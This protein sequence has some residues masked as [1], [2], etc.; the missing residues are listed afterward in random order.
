MTVHATRRHLLQTAGFGLASLPLLAARPGFA[1][2]TGKTYKIALSNSYIGNKWR[3]EMEN[4]FKAALAM[5][6]FKSQVVGSIY[7]SGNDVSKQSQQMSN[8]IA[9][10]VDAIVIDA[11]S[12][13]ALNGI[14]HQATSRGILVVS[15]DSGVTAPSAIKVNISQYR[16]RQGLGGMDRQ[17]DGRPGQCHHGDGRCRHRGRS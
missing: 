11:A 13:T 9:E 8:M 7:N 3:L 10:R 2:S 5:E 17:A 12:P 4:V 16:P 1:Q 15:F 14:I 6:P